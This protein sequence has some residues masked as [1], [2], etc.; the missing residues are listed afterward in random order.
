MNRY[1]LLAMIILGGCQ[2]TTSP[3]PLGATSTDALM[4]L[5]PYTV[6]TDRSG[7]MVLH[8]SPQKIQV[9]SRVAPSYPIQEQLPPGKK[10]RCKATVTIDK[11]GHPYE[12]EV[13]DCLQ[14]F[15]AES[16][17]ALEKWRWEPVI[18]RGEPIRARTDITVNFTRQGA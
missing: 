8:L 18:W 11:S 16:E 7:R 15:Q 10:V 6:E 1:L 4:A 17:R 13:V 14:P 5:Q 2:K 12:V 3:E 9:K